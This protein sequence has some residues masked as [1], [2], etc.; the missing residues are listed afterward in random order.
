MFDLEKSNSLKFSL[1]RS[2]PLLAM[3]ITIAFLC[4]INTALADDSIEDKN[5]KEF[6]TLQMRV[7]AYCPCEKCCGQFA[8]GITANG[9]KI[10][11]G[12]TF[13]AADSRYPFETELIIP[14]YSRSNPVK[15]LDRG[16]AIKG[17][18]I[19]V[20]FHTHEKALQ[21]GVQYLDV[22]IRTK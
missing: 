20:F 9:H 1:I 10:Q 4:T 19:D 15:V 14:G 22:K 11:P 18:R 3:I 5:V 8:D 17:N 16:G 12:D 21:W 7:T 2:K 13:V 6:Q